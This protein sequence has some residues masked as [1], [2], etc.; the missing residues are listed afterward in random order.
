MLITLTSDGASAFAPATAATSADYSIGLKNWFGQIVHSLTLDYNGT[1]IIQQTPFINMWNSFKLMT[2]LSW[3]DV[4]TMGATIGFYPDDP[5]SWSYNTTPANSGVGVCNNTNF[6]TNSF[7]TIVNGA[8]NNYKSANGNIGFLKRQTYINYED[9][10]IAGVGPGPSNVLYSALLPNS[11]ATTLWKSRISSKVNAG[12]GLPGVYQISVRATIYLKHLH[13]FFQMVPLL[14]GV[15]M[16]MTLNLNNSSCIITSSAA[17][18]GLTSS[19]VPVGGV[20]PLMM[21]F[22]RKDAHASSPCLIPM[23]CPSPCL[24]SSPCLPPSH[25]PSLPPSFSSTGVL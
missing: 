15:Y 11:A 25:P 24:A 6:A 7:G 4:Q 10:A 19:S 20:Q 12:G 16:K 1:T 3:N 13:S 18:L 22:S 8:F 21:T 9:D 5:L 17:G 23:P 2:S 14:K